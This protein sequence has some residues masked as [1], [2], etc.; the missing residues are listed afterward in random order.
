[1]VY[2]AAAFIAVWLLVTLFVVYV[3]Q[4]QRALEQEMRSL[5]ET[6]KERTTKN[7]KG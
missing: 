5:E 4:R 7:K 3:V 1:M 2:L 6:I